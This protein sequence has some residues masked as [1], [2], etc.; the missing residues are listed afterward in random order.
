MIITV[1][2]FFVL[3]IQVR[4]VLLFRL[5]LLG[6]IL[7]LLSCNYA[8]TPTKLEGQ[9]ELQRALILRNTESMGSVN[10]SIRAE[11]SDRL[12]QGLGEGIQISRGQVLEDYQ[13]TDELLLLFPA[14]PI[15]GLE[16]QFVLS[17]KVQESTTATGGT[18]KLRQAQMLKQGTQFSVQM[19]MQGNAT[20]AGSWGYTRHPSIRQVYVAM[21]DD[22]DR[23]Y[24][25]QVFHQTVFPV[26]SLDLRSARSED[27]WIAIE[28]VLPLQLIEQSQVID[29]CEMLLE[30]LDARLTT[31]TGQ[32]LQWSNSLTTL[33]NIE[34]V[35]SET[36]RRSLQKGRLFNVTIELDNREITRGQR[37]R[38]V[39]R[40]A[41]TLVEENGV[42]KAGTIGISIK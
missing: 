20:V 14:K 21:F 1:W 5:V 32:Y 31:G 39:I 11:V 10:Q 7:L 3:T 2:L 4:M 13:D 30:A 16:G 18:L 34:A 28:F 25:S 9:M 12:R 27:N 36:E 40:H 37:I 23:V 6:S 17:L 38:P 8:E 24:E 22:P 29:S 15:N 35:A 41:L 26:Q 42:K 19:M 33:D